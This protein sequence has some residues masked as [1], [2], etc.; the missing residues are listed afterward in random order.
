M[1]TL[2]TEKSKA[3]DLWS[4]DNVRICGVISV[5]FVH[6]LQ[7]VDR[8]HTTLWFIN[9]HGSGRLFVLSGFLYGKS[10]A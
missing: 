10:R 4:L 5:V 9:S 8:L 7:A 1:T 2:N 6:A 3:R